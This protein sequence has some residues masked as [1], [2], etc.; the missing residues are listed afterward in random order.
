MHHFGDCDTVLKERQTIIIESAIGYKCLTLKFEVR[1]LFVTWV[2]DQKL[3]IYQL[4]KSL[5]MK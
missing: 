1:D 4:S 5:V 2:L 3:G